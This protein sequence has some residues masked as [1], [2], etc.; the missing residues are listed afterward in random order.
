MIL[1]QVLSDF[2]VDTS[3]LESSVQCNDSLYLMAVGQQSSL[4]CF[5]RNIDKICAFLI[6]IS[7]KMKG[8]RSLLS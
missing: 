5:N 4:S 6:R 7:V 1:T 2:R 3:L 8:K